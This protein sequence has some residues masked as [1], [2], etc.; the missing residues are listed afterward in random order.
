MFTLVL[1]TGNLLYEVNFD[2]EGLEF[3]PYYLSL[4]IDNIPID[5]LDKIFEILVL[6]YTA[7]DEYATLSR[8]S[9]DIGIDII[10]KYAPKHA[11]KLLKIMES[12]LSSN[13]I[14]NIVFLGVLAPYVKGNKNLEAIQNKITQLFN[15]DK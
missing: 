7:N 1:K 2:Q 14:S 12:F 4:N 3:L 13:S 8:M 6:K 5:F 9:L 10:K 15:D 11:E